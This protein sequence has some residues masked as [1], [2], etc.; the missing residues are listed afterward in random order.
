MARFQIRY[1]TG[2]GPNERDDVEIEAA[3]YQLANGVYD[4]YD[5][6]QIGAGIEVEIPGGK[7]IRTVQSKYVIEIIRLDT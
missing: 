6:L 7:V 1:E 5:S 4:F 2:K 3:T